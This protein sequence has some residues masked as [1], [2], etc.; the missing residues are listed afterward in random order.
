VLPCFGGGFP[1]V[2]LAVMLVRDLLEQVV[3][4]ADPVDIENRIMTL[5]R[6]GPLARVC[7]KRIPNFTGIATGV[8]RDAAGL[9]R[10]AA[11]EVQVVQ[12]AALVQQYE[13]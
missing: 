7:R 6:E 1:P 8:G 5:A 10:L 4:A 3:G 2:E 9:R 13:P 12:Q 11:A